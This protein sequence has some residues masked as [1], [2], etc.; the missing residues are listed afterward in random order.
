MNWQNG[1][2]SQENGAIL[3]T[4]PRRKLINFALPLRLQMFINVSAVLI[5]TPLI[6]HAHH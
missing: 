5:A 1:V 2:I 3:A 6:L 4:L